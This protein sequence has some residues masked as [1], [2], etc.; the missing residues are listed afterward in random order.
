MC[1]ACYAAWLTVA[2]IRQESA[3]YKVPRLISLQEGD[4]PLS[5]SLLVPLECSWKGQAS[6]V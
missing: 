4:Q 1:L 6:I 2:D 3:L 5:Q